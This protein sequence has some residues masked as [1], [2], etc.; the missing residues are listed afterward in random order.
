MNHES[1]RA[2]CLAVRHTPWSH[3]AGMPT[4]I[5]N[6]AGMRIARCDFD[7]DFNHSAAHA[8]AAYIAAM[9]PTTTLAL[10]DD[11]DQLQH[12]HRKVETE[13][14]DRYDAMKE[15]KDALLREALRA[16]KYHSDQT[17]PIEQTFDMMDAIKM[18]LSK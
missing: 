14:Q 1:L 7:G 4:N 15:R 3:M 17:R 10:L 11:I 12:L 9:D 16:L 6:A 13:W 5:L 18:E 2:L 8:N